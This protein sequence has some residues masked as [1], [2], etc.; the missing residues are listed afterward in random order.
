MMENED[1]LSSLV[2]KYYESDMFKIM[3]KS[4]IKECMKP[5]NEK[6]KAL[7]SRLRD[8]EDKLKVQKE[9]EKAEQT[10]TPKSQ[11][12]LNLATHLLNTID[13]SESFIISPVSIILAIHPFFKSATPQ[14]RLKWAKL[15]LEGGTPDDMTEYFVDLLSVVRASVLWYEIKRIDGK[16]NDP[17]IQH[18]YR[19]EG[20]HGL[21]ENVFKDFLSTK[22]KFI[23]FESDEMIVN[24]INYNP[25]FDEIIH[26]FFTSKRTFYSTESSPQTMGFMEWRAHQHHFSEDDTFQMIEIQ[27]RQHIS[28]H[29]F[30][31]KIRFGLRNALKNLK[32][33]EKLYQ[34]ISTAEKKL[35]NIALPRFNINMET[36]LASFMRSIG[37]EKELYDTISEKVYGSIPSFVHKSQFELTFKKH[38]LEELL[39]NDDYVDD[40]DYTGLVHD[41]APYCVYFPTKLEFL[42]DHPFLFMLVKDSHVVYFGCYQ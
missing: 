27:M 7:E 16:E 8:L 20:Y 1:V 26:K 21:E 24:S 6:V 18:L 14:L 34:L 40:T 12:E 3:L 25:I 38:S 36:D 41:S 5:L 37:I 23:E 22:L 32:N 39:Y 9:L 10:P 2:S 13:I 35:V 42:A 29:I 15:F 4:T 33:G 11:L 19:N 31:P 17:T 28:L 30:L